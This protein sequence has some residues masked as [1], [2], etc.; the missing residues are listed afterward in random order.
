MFCMV[1][2]M[3]PKRFKF[4]NKQILHFQQKKKQIFYKQ[5]I[6]HSFRM[7]QRKSANVIA[8]NQQGCLL[9]EFDC[10]WMWLPIDGRSFNRRLLIGF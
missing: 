1:G 10:I 8:A 2:I 4:V 6:I 3:Y 7:I 5:S 9:C